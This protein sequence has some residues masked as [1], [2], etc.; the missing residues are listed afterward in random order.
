M[1]FEE[2]EISVNSNGG[3]ELT[4]RL[5]G[6]RL[7]AELLDNFQIICSRV[8]EL[9][10]DKIRV[11]FLHDLPEDPESAKLKDENYRNKFHQFV[12]VSE[13]QYQ[14]YRNYLGLP[15]DL[16]SIVLENCIEPIETHTKPKD[17]IN[18]AYFSTP[19]RGL[20]ILIPVFTELAKEYPEI[21]LNVFSSF[22]IYGW[23]DA[24]KQFEPIFEACRN[25]PQITYHGAV[26]HAEMI[27]QLKQQHILAYP[28]TWPETGCRVLMESM[29]ARLM[30][31][32]PNFAA[33]PCTSGGL[34]NMY[35][36][37]AN[38]N[39]HA[40]QFY[41][42][43]KGAIEDIKKDA[44]GLD[45]HLDLVKFYADNRFASQR[46]AMGWMN[47]LTALSAK[48]PTVESRQTPSEQFIYKTR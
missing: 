37:S 6:Q 43:L 3:T 32:H 19:H 22:D 4:K 20:N 15:Y 5:L 42:A 13:W 17:K 39:E 40:N 1:G 8:R 31:V 26:P 36:G 16:K 35:V 29:S 10:E 28:S 45:G 18:L 46:I 7:P 41:A 48:Y 2:N 9:Q 11:L 24:D 34:T 33:L 12:F 25:H 23:K 27:E 30:C 44:E 47:L 21:H 38:Q 14:Q